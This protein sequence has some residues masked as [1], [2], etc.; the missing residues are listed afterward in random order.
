ML[1][2]VREDALPD[3]LGPLDANPAPEHLRLRHEADLA[4]AAMQRKEAEEAHLYTSVVLVTLEDIERESGLDCV[5]W[6]N[7]T[8]DRMKKVSWAR[9]LILA[10][11]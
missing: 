11:F 8:L 5:K 10:S 2:Y 4:R 1:V 6:R 7:V 3:A 9:T